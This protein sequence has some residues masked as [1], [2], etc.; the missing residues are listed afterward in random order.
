MKKIIVILV[1]CLISIPIMA[2]AAISNSIVKIYVVRSNFDYQNPWQ[3]RGQSSGTGSG[4]II[5][6]NRILTSAHVV[7]NSTLIQVRR[8]GEASRYTA[9]V[10]S[11]SHISDLAILIVDDLSFFENSEA[12]E[13]GE[14]PQL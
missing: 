13:I 5:D 4:C 1:F 9:K 3:M 10:Y 7:S 2:D 14:L 11:I 8:A 6:G 12:L